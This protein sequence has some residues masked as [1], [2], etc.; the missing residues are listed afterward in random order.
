[1]YRIAIDLYIFND[2]D[3][4]DSLWAYR[5]RSR[6]DTNYSFTSILRVLLTSDFLS[7]PTQGPSGRVRE[8]PL[9]MVEAAPE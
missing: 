6:V 5:F 1:M 7:R 2:L 4:K 9:E 8:H 3:S